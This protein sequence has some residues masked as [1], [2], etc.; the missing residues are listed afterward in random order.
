[1]I[2]LFQ[3]I[4]LQSEDKDKVN[5]LGNKVRFTRQFYNKICITNLGLDQKPFASFVPKK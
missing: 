1:M 5:R 4:I 3:N 2:I